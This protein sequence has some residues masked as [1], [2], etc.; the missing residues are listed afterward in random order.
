M[1]LTGKEVA[2]AAITM[3]MSA[4]IEE[5]KILKEDY[6]TKGIKTCAVNIGGNVINSIPKVLESTLVSAKRNNLV[7]DK[8]VYDGAILGA[9][10]E[11]LGVIVEKASGFNAGG[12]VGVARCGEHIV[13]CI[14]LSIG[15]LHLDEVVIGLGHRVIPVN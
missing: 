1:K 10:R 5:E 13:V 6:K 2:K 8:H 3:A 15:L 7:E 9:T 4:D 14:F 11:A 12:K